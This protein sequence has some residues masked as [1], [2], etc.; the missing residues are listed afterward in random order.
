MKAIEKLADF[1]PEI[2]HALNK[3]GWYCKE[4]GF[5]GPELEKLMNV[6]IS[7]ASILMDCMEILHREVEQ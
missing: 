3:I 6:G 4:H 1:G 7:A 2:N 5:T